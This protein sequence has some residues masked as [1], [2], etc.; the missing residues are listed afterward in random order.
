MK[1]TDLS[2]EK[3]GMWLM[4]VQVSFLKCDALS[5]L[6]NRYSNVL[7]SKVTMSSFK[8]SR[9]YSLDWKKEKKK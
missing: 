1:I 5:Q 9:L 8:M 6:Q 4:V 3:W 2:G 7:L